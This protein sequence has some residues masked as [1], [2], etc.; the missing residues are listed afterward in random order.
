VFAAAS[1]LAASSISPAILEIRA[2]RF[3]GFAGAHATITVAANAKQWAEHFHESPAEERAEEAENAANGF[4][5]GIVERFTT[6]AAEGEYEVQV[7]SA[8]RSAVREVAQWTR[9]EKLRDRGSEPEQSTAPGVA[10]SV[11]FSEVIPQQ[12][13]SASNVVFPVGRCWFHVSDGLSHV[14]SRAQGKRATLALAR[15]LD[16]RMRRICD[17]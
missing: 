13:E 16:R 6:S 8:H 14:S 12:G 3:P 2:G 1:A 11:L 15:A 17:P 5:E 7:F 4:E 10:G 9:E